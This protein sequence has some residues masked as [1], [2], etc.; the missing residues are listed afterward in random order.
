MLVEGVK[1]VRI[2][3]LGKAVGMPVG[4]NRLRRG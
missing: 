1:P 2:D 3:N 4:L